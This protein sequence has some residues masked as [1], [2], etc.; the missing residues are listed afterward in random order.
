MKIEN[1][2]FFEWAEEYGNYYGVTQSEI[3][4]VK[5]LNKIGIW[6]MGYK[7]VR[8]AKKLLPNI[9][10][11]LINAPLNQIENRI[12][13]RDKNVTEQFIEDRMEYTKEWLK[14]ISLYDYVVMNLDGRL[15]QA[16]EEVFQ[17]LKK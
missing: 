3:E 15:N 4:R 12:R 5:N 9:K 1:N 7:G 13:T 2:D 6:K 17:I 8:T 16:V 14:H 11:I 10:S